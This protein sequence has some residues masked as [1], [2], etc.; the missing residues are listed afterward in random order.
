MEVQRSSKWQRTQ[1]VKCQ[2]TKLS[3]VCRRPPLLHTHTHTVLEGSEELTPSHTVLRACS[4]S[5]SNVELQE[6]STVALSQ[7]LHPIKAG[8]ESLNVAGLM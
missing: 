7:L 6:H 2:V 4:E 5:F 3:G 1:M 8:F